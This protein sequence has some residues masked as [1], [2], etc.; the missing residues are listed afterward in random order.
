[1]GIERDITN[2][3][4]Y[5][6]HARAAAQD[7]ERHVFALLKRVDSVDQHLS[8]IKSGIATLAMHIG[9]TQGMLDSILDV[10]KTREEECS[11]GK[12]EGQEAQPEVHR[13]EAH[14][15]PPGDGPGS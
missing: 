1:M 4:L 3:A 8:D 11:C 13:N 14:P 7:A 2:A 6:E 5:A 12:E 9:E 15:S 10:L